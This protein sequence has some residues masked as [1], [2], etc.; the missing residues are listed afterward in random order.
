MPT[1][2]SY[3]N[4]FGSSTSDSDPATSGTDAIW[5]NAGVN[6]HISLSEKTRNKRKK[7][8]WLVVCLLYIYIKVNLL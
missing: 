1:V 2:L 5:A 6:K 8:H 3:Q 4:T 7:G